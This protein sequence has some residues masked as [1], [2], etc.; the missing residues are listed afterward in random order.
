MVQQARR[1]KIENKTREKEREHRGEVLKITLKRMR[2]GLPAAL[3][4]RFS[5]KRIEIER[6]KRLAS[7][8]GYTGRA[9]SEAG[10]KLKNPNLW[11]IE[12]MGDPEK[13]EEFT[14]LE[15]EFKAL[16]EERRARTEGR[17]IDLD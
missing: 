7:E 16:Q 1:V 9:K 3:L 8:G 5:P 15:E 10:M 6:I 11:K 2:K 12:E 4:D 13:Q 17:K 14:K